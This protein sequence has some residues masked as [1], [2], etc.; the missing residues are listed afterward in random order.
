MDRRKSKIFPREIQM[1]GHHLSINKS[2]F[3]IHLC[4]EDGSKKC[5]SSKEIAEEAWMI[6]RS[7]D[8][9]SKDELDGDPVQY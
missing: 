2:M 3:K 6:G 7:L 8:H 4:H 1:N 9:R 5:G